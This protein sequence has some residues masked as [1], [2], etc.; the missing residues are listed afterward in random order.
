MLLIE[1]KRMAKKDLYQ[2]ISTFSDMEEAVSSTVNMQNKSMPC[3]Y[4][5]VTD[6]LG[7]GDVVVSVKI[8]PRLGD[9]YVCVYGLET[10]ERNARCVYDLLLRHKIVSMSND[11]EI[12]FFD[13]KSIE[14]SLLV[15]SLYEQLRNMIVPM[16]KPEVSYHSFLFLNEA[17]RSEKPKFVNLHPDL[18]TVDITYDGSMMHIICKL[19]QV[20]HE[21]IYFN[22]DLGYFVGLNECMH[23][24]IDSD[25]SLVW[26]YEGYI[27]SH[28][29]LC[30]QCVTINQVLIIHDLTIVSEC[31]YIN[32][33]VSV[34]K[35]SY[36]GMT[37]FNEKRDHDRA[38]N[39]QLDQKITDSQLHINANF[40]VNDLLF[41][42]ADR[43][44]V[45][46]LFNLAASSQMY[47]DLFHIHQSGVLMN[48]SPKN[49]QRSVRLQA[50]E[51]A[52]DYLSLIF[53]EK[54]NFEVN[55]FNIKGYF[56][57]N[58]GIIR[59]KS[60]V[61]SETSCLKSEDACIKISGRMVS[62]G[63]WQADRTSIEVYALYSR[64][65]SLISSGLKIHDRWLHGGHRSELPCDHAQLTSLLDADGV[66][67]T[68]NLKNSCVHVKN[69]LCVSKSRVLVS[70]DQS[71]IKIEHA[72]Q[73]QEKSILQIHGE[74]AVNALNIEMALS[75]QFHAEQLCLTVVH[76]IESQSSQLYF[77]HG[78]IS[79]KNLVGDEDSSLIL[80]SSSLCAQSI[81]LGQ[82]KALQDDQVLQT[83]LRGLD[84]ILAAS[85]QHTCYTW[86]KCIYTVFSKEISQD[87]M[88]LCHYWSCNKVD[89]TR[90]FLEADK[91]FD[92]DLLDEFY[93]ASQLIVPIYSIELMSDDQ[94][95]EKWSMLDGIVAS[96]KTFFT[97]EVVWI[98]LSDSEYVVQ[99]EKVLLY[100]AIYALKFNTSIVLYDSIGGSFW[101][102]DRK[103]DKPCIWEIMGSG[104]GYSSF[105]Q[106]VNI[107]YLYKRIQ[108]HLEVHAQYSVS[109]QMIQTLTLLKYHTLDR[110]IE[111][112]IERLFFDGEACHLVPLRELFPIDI[113]IFLMQKTDLINVQ[114]VTG[115]ENDSSYGPYKSL[116][117]YYKN[118]LQSYNKLLT[119]SYCLMSNDYFTRCFQILRHVKNIV[120]ATDDACEDNIAQ[121]MHAIQL[122]SPHLVIRNHISVNHLHVLKNI[123]LT[124]YYLQGL[125]CQASSAA[126]VQSSVSMKYF[127]KI[128]DTA[129]WMDVVLDMDKACLMVGELLQ[130][131]SHDDLLYANMKG[132]I[133]SCCLLK[134][135]KMYSNFIDINYLCMMDKELE[136][137]S[138]KINADVMAGCA[139][140]IVH[141]S[142]LYGSLFYQGHSLKIDNS[143]FDYKQ[144]HIDSLYSHHTLHQGGDLSIYGNS[145][146][147]H[148][149]VSTQSFI[150][151]GTLTAHQMSFNQGSSLKIARDARA[152]FMQHEDYIIDVSALSVQGS[153]I[154]NGRWLI[155]TD[156]CVSGEIYS[157]D[158]MMQARGR[159]DFYK[160]SQIRGTALTLK[161]D[162][163]WESRGMVRLH[164]DLNVWSNQAKIIG[165]LTC[166]GDVLVQ[167]NQALEML[168]GMDVKS[169]TVSSCYVYLGGCIAANQSVAIRRSWF[170]W[171]NANIVSRGYSCESW[172]SIKNFSST[173]KNKFGFKSFSLIALSQEF[174]TWLPYTSLT[175][176]ILINTIE[177]V[178]PL[179]YQPCISLLSYGEKNIR[180]E[181]VSHCLGKTV[182]FLEKWS[183]VQLS[184]VDGLRSKAH[185]QL[186]RC[187]P[188]A[189]D[190]DIFKESLD[191][192]MGIMKTV[193]YG[194][195]RYQYSYESVDNIGK[196]C[197]VFR[198]AMMHVTAQDEDSIF[199]IVNADVGCSFRRNQTVM[200][201]IFNVSPIS[202]IG[203]R[204]ES[205]LMVYDSP[206]TLRMG[207][208]SSIHAHDHYRLGCRLQGVEL[209]QSKRIYQGYGYHMHV[210]DYTSSEYMCVQSSLTTYAYLGSMKCDHLMINDRAKVHFHCY[211]FDWLFKSYASFLPQSSWVVQVNHAIVKGHLSINYV[212]F[213]S[214]LFILGNQSTLSINHSQ[215]LVSGCQVFGSVVSDSFTMV[216]NFK[217]HESGSWFQYDNLLMLKHA[218]ID[219]VLH[220][221]R[222]DAVCL[223]DTLVIGSLGEMRVWGGAGLKSVTCTVYGLVHFCMNGSSELSDKSIG[224]SPLSPTGMIDHLYLMH[225]SHV[226][227]NEATLVV[228]TCHV[229]SSILIENY[230]S[231]VAQ[232]AN[233]HKTSMISGHG[234]LY[235][236]VEKG[237][238]D[239]LVNVSVLYL[240]HKKINDW[241]GLFCGSG[242]YYRIQPQHLVYMTDESLCIDKKVVRN[243]GF[244]IIAKNLKITSDLITDQT[245]ELCAMEM[246]SISGCDLL[247]Q[248][249][250]ITSQGVMDVT[251]AHLNVKNM[252]NICSFGKLYIGDRA[253]SDKVTMCG[254]DITLVS[255]SSDVVLEKM[256]VVACN[257]ALS[258]LSI[259]IKDSVL[260]AH[261][262]SIDGTISLISRNNIDITSSHF[263]ASG[264]I[265]MTAENNV[266]IRSSMKY[267]YS[268]AMMAQYRQR[269]QSIF[270]GSSLHS[271]LG[272]IR[273]VSHSGDVVL[274]ST[275][276]VSEMGFDILAYGDVCLLTLDANDRTLAASKHTYPS[277][278]T[279]ASYVYPCR[280]DCLSTD[281]VS[282]IH[283]ANGQIISVAT[284]FYSSGQMIFY[285]KG[286]ISFLS[287]MTYSNTAK[288][289]FKI[290]GAIKLLEYCGD[291]LNLPQALSCLKAYE[292]SKS[293]STRSLNLLGLLTAVYGSYYTVSQ[294]YVN[295]T[296]KKLIYEQSKL[297]I[298]HKTF[299]PNVAVSVKL[300]YRIRKQ[301]NSY[302]HALTAQSLVVYSHA[303]LYV[304]G[305]ILCDSVSIDAN[306]FILDAQLLKASNYSYQFQLYASLSIDRGLHFGLRI[307]RERV[308]YL[309]YEASVVNVSHLV[310]NVKHFVIGGSMLIADKMEGSVLDTTLYGKSNS[311]EHVSCGYAFDNVSNIN[312]VRQSSTD[313]QECTAVIS[314]RHNY[315]HS[316]LDAS[317]GDA[318]VV[319][320]RDD[321]CIANINYQPAVT[322]KR[323]SSSMMKFNIFK[324]KNI[325]EHWHQGSLD[326]QTDVFT[327]VHY[328]K[329]SKVMTV[330]RRQS[331]RVMMHEVRNNDNKIIILYSPVII[332]Q[333]MSMSQPFRNHCNTTLDVVTQDI[334]AKL[335]L[336]G[337]DDALKVLQMVAY[338]SNLVYGE[339]GNQYPNRLLGYQ[340]HESIV[341]PE[342]GLRMQVYKNNDR[343]MIAFSGTP[344][345]DRAFWRALLTDDLSILL[346]RKLPSV[347]L[348][349][350]HPVFLKYW[351]KDCMMLLT[352]HSRGAA[353]VVA[354]LQGTNSKNKI[355]IVFE[356]PKYLRIIPDNVV[357]VQGGLNIITWQGSPKGVLHVRAMPTHVN[358]FAQLVALK[359][360]KIS[361][362]S[363]GML[364][365]Y[366]QH[367]LQDFLSPVHK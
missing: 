194:Y 293:F 347:D 113:Q 4:F 321:H 145:T 310:I 226:I 358:L 44:T 5:V 109:C 37:S 327:S 191:W 25:S 271:S 107:G 22:R 95:Q 43:I 314:V 51:F 274:I 275:H 138:S 152:H 132:T 214:S 203:F 348:L 94:W 147:E 136:I 110:S 116:F 359:H 169:L 161:C 17:E 317:S 250:S 31:L 174:I 57:F 246:L 355:G 27:G 129:Y 350:S 257:I 105:N 206:L 166:G 15:L 200:G 141:H 215:F 341:F 279:R 34:D 150:I 299:N 324:F 71:T 153:L 126:I 189:L 270:N 168:G 290:N 272:A 148:T 69:F 283:A 353:V 212:T 10:F 142:H 72:L 311:I 20:H 90:Y 63:V 162:G 3:W 73:L 251:R 229:Y 360:K 183:A 182:R 67:S 9:L 303:T 108:T 163:C 88:K 8:T 178:L 228:N 297:Y 248:N 315:V 343:Y 354:L 118:S 21:V 295:H 336:K 112:M 149:N 173:I 220:I 55:E 325:I 351:E 41:I 160:T 79:C 342:T 137:F 225:G 278:V 58:Q 52:C 97:Q 286:D 40:Y 221:E 268:T 244:G 196:L 245:L 301:Y 224:R 122:L 83:S 23:L 197:G 277:F 334:Q 306:T 61:V 316:L 33:G 207:M 208:Y 210:V 193:Y 32:A 78:E 81:T 190:K 120:G 243:L 247:A 230:C 19:T 49:E 328:E 357:I 238:F 164:G 205:A 318:L 16:V 249:L 45:N 175:K 96:L 344:K 7:M 82:L 158:A 227:L 80:C 91:V 264:M 146:M 235:L 262:I 313:I 106:A 231:I 186:L 294:A 201:C 255:L 85:L 1:S 236:R 74:C 287:S 111:G 365:T 332:S 333:W 237:I 288:Y 213:F 172:V 198:L 53:L 12:V 273:I 326:K 144:S 50:N 335:N 304:Q 125:T 154:T 100:Y 139:A 103:N 134:K 159:I 170:I 56:E 219:G 181:F 340:L 77:I 241:Y 66:I 167:S 232:T 367:M 258:G 338:V 223:S 99:I 127:F 30:S 104:N 240:Y 260:Y 292:D 302:R 192:A 171:N 6:E 308:T 202:F 329:T 254:R 60:L 364:E 87:A 366:Q 35:F 119:H 101:V 300:C 346:H 123:T 199:A 284:Q 345:W 24:T 363:M 305:D 356:N 216:D 233:F 184:E 2:F 92:V 84:H 259:D 155:D 176:K 298:A 156:I 18:V 263:D 70:S 54:I 256:G 265:V 188:S 130:E 76:K 349:L 252:M 307:N 312:I 86:K 362:V 185:A 47:V 64:T 253:Y 339:D 280:I 211:R 28:L 179:L 242:G 102:V 65:L 352:G 165:D 180:Y 157:I 239:P 276:V 217:I 124:R 26:D 135:T 131:D 75:S 218:S 319:S 281:S 68:V 140:V 13:K 337:V 269:C 143:L 48:V 309:Q 29:H 121:N 323:S 14:S 133:R 36:E 234:C 361:S 42:Q 320:S 39:N 93:S 46:K 89:G 195:K 296:L 267:S 115:Y 62:E 261:G 59:S 222:E 282:R 128:V 177:Y 151:N 117:N 114:Y 291:D 289:S 38:D 330:Y 285:A 98:S 11:V 187:A 331:G 322:E 209:T 266:N 204:N